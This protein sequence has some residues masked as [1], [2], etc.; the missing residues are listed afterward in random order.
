MFVGEGL[1]IVKIVILTIVS[2]IKCNCIKILVEESDS[3][4]LWE[5]HICQ[6]LKTLL[7]RMAEGYVPFKKTGYTEKLES[8][9]QC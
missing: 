5:K 1:N 3:K 2:Q 6:L 8:S 4:L 7:K 9:E